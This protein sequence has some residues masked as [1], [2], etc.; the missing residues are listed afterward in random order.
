MT[1]R[2]V[3]RRWICHMS[4]TK[5]YTVPCS[6][7][8]IIGFLLPF[9]Y[10]CP[11]VWYCIL[12]PIL[13]IMYICHRGDAYPERHMSHV[14]VHTGHV[15]QI[16]GKTLCIVCICPCMHSMH[17]WTRHSWYGYTV[18]VT[19]SCDNHDITQCMHVVR[20]QR[21]W[22]LRHRMANTCC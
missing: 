11:L 2:Y 3:T 6:H 8:W 12:V 15:I 20:S 22:Y 7:A 16:C 14:M 10:A 13:L 5:Q 17:A 4:F 18:Y 21:Q 19:I 1:C 9:M